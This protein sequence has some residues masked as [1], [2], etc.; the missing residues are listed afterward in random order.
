MTILPGQG[1]TVHM[2]YSEDSPKQLF[3]NNEGRG[4][5]Q[6]LDLWVIPG[7]QL[8]LHVVHE[9]QLP[10][11]PWTKKMK[12]TEAPLIRPSGS[13]EKYGIWFL[14]PDLSPSKTRK[15]SIK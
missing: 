10:H 2:P 9:A 14:A 1:L 12:E 7:P 8:E 4:L 15:L 13:I 11:A 3:P 5:S 6:A